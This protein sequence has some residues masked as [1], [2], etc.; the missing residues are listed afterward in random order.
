MSAHVLLGKSKEAKAYF[1]KIE[2]DIL[3]GIDVD[4]NKWADHD[5]GL[6]YGI[7]YSKIIS[8]STP[9]KFIQNAKRGLNLLKAMGYNIYIISG[10]FDG[11]MDAVLKE[12]PK[13][14]V[15]DVICVQI[16]TDQDGN[17]VGHTNNPLMDNK[18]KALRHF[19]KKHN[20][21]LDSTIA[22]G[23]G[24]NDISMMEIAGFSIAFRPNNKKLKRIVDVSIHSDN[25]WN[26]LRFIRGL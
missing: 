12:L 21:S 13:D 10:T 18:A 1:N 17:V 25:F 2:R 3:A 26:V 8:A 4:Y 24:S 7:P 22:I 16:N 9:V 20:F 11:F 15:T 23:N 14:L 19:A 6:W 5:I